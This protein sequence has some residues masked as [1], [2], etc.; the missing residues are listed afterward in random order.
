MRGI[1]LS[2]LVCALA[3][4]SAA[5]ADARVLDTIDAVHQ[6][7]ASARDVS[8]ARLYVMDV[9]D[10]W[11]FGEHDEGRLMVGTARNFRALD[12]HVSLLV[13]RY[14]ALSFEVG[15]EGA[16]RLREAAMAG[17]RLRVG[18]F[19]AFDDRSRQ[20]C[21][22]RNRH[23]VTIVRTDVAY[24][25][26]VGEGDARLA[27]VE[28]DR[29]SAWND[30]LVAFGIEGRGPR[31]AVGDARFSNGQ[32]APER[33]QRILGAA[34]PR[35]AIGRCHAEGVRRGASEEGQVVIRLNIETRT[36][37]VRRAD[38]ALSSIGDHAEAE[39]IARVLGSTGSLSPAPS[40]WQAEV[41]D[42]SVP[43]RLVTD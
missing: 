20:P 35:E 36:G 37:R 16:T 40:S 30:D 5:L 33:W 21:L 31:A 17:A 41:V 27:R 39:C 10:G 19:I 28:T 9:E 11:S 4:P 34:Q 38:V 32:A 13:P 8:R 7:C 22:V 3:L 43:V 24:L 26:L 23:A 2:S 29:L 12:G 14:E 1:V 18:F 15:V 42:L 25:E 6:A